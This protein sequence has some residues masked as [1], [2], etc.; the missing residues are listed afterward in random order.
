LV[1]AIQH[2]CTVEMTGQVQQL[3]DVG[4]NTDNVG[5]GQ[6][7]AYMDQIVCSEEEASLER[8][9]EIEMV[10]S[11]VALRKPGFGYL[12]LRDPT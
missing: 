5:I 4:L 8:E 7:M 2:A 3:P 1:L 11:F 6:S 10:M 12:I 9:R